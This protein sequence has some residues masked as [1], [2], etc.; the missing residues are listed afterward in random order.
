MASGYSAGQASLE[1]TSVFP[2]SFSQCDQAAEGLYTPP[3]KPHTCLASLVS[4]GL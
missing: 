3:V 4:E 1:E 2:L